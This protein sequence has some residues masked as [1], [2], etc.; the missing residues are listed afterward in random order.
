MSTPRKRAWWTTQQGCNDI[1]ALASSY[2][3]LGDGT[4]VIEPTIVDRG[5]AV[6]PH[7]ATNR[8]RQH[9]VANDLNALLTE[10]EE[11]RNRPE[12]AAAASTTTTTSAAGNAHHP[13]AFAIYKRLCQTSTS[14]MEA[15][16]EAD[17]IGIGGH[18]GPADTCRVFSSNPMEALQIIPRAYEEEYLID[19]NN[20]EEEE[21]VTKCRNGKACVGMLLPLRLPDW[22][23]SGGASPPGFILRAFVTPVERQ[24]QNNTTTLLCGGLCLLCHRRDVSTRHAAAMLGLKPV[25]GVIQKF[26]NQQGTGEYG[27][28]AFLEVGGKFNGVVQPMVRFRFTD[29]AYVAAAAAAAGR[30]N[31][32]NHKQ[33]FVQRN[34]DFHSASHIFASFSPCRCIQFFSENEKELQR[35]AGRCIHHPLLS[36]KTTMS[37]NDVYDDDNL[38]Q[39]HEHVRTL[40]DQQINAYRG[41]K[42]RRER[43]WAD[44]TLD[45]F[46]LDLAIARAEMHSLF[47]G[48]EQ[49]KMI[50][51]DCLCAGS[52]MWDTSAAL[53]AL[54]SPNNNSSSSSGSNASNINNGDITPVQ[55]IAMM[56]MPQRGATLRFTRSS[57]VKTTT[58]SSRS[59]VQSICDPSSSSLSSAITKEARDF[60]TWALRRFLGGDWPGV[61]SRSNA[62][63]RCCLM[64]WFAIQSGPQ[65]RFELICR[66]PFLV[67]IAVR[68]A[69]VRTATWHGVFDRLL[70]LTKSEKKWAAM[71]KW[72]LTTAEH[73]RSVFYTRNG[74]IDEAE[75]YAKRVI[76]MTGKNNPPTFPP[77]L[78]W[79][80]DA[81][82]H[83]MKEVPRIRV[84]VSTRLPLSKPFDP[85]WAHEDVHAV[86]KAMRE[87][88]HTPEVCNALLVVYNA[89]IAATSRSLA[90]VIIAETTR[91]PELLDVFVFVHDAFHIRIVGTPMRFS[92]AAPPQR[93]FVV[94]PCC[95]SFKGFSVRAD[96]EPPPRT[97]MTDRGRKR[98][99]KELV[100]TAVSRGSDKVTYDFE[101]GRVYCYPR[102]VAGMRKED[103]SSSSS[104]IIEEEDDVVMSN[105][106][107]EDDDE[108][109]P[110][111][112]KKRRSVLARVAFSMFHYS[113]CFDT[114][115]VP[116]R[117]HN[118]LVEL[119]GKTLSLCSSC[120]APC[121]RPMP[122]APAASWTCFD[123]SSSNG[124]QRPQ[125]AKRACFYCGDEEVSSR[126]D[127]SQI[128]VFR[129]D[130][131]PRMEFLCPAHGVHPRHVAAATTAATAIPWNANVLYTYIRSREASSKRSTQQ[132]R[133][134][135]RQQQLALRKR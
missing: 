116:L 50:P 72:T 2:L 107:G 56:A 62:R 94:C 39:L 101:T 75:T 100:T 80:W 17:R 96:G 21:E 14:A 33:R 35:R 77:P 112:R 42:Q 64:R 27:P 30:G 111:K 59:S 91:T 41:V 121:S 127:F 12:N 125:T 117:I 11:M 102:H 113:D 85:R 123:C 23:T 8:L 89:S 1:R 109:D 98:A 22:P 5:V 84:S 92:H 78:A 43:K 32:N 132:Q 76:T 55:A 122:T 108:D 4:N 130:G 63:I 61:S 66:V 37:E 129:G 16:A 128:R 38:Q 119:W 3:A 126:S 47:G 26:A 6:A 114:E 28:H 103:P 135:R 52:W 65:E 51:L 134:R 69:L 9:V 110:R 49:K 73:V 24:R 67:L 58:R 90:N 29:Y 74:D 79:F 97:A 81:V 106:N 105:E 86:I 15:S 31:N 53:L 87:V 19:P 88:G 70:Q 7:P 124:V 44:V 93:D 68:E 131:P 36:K 133:Q 40:D 104:S 83:A 46:Q 34:V 115:C 25:S 20:E 71:S 82:I 54:L 18:R 120:G 48:K 45:V 99:A 57:A 118:N 95:R 60:V 10:N 13:L